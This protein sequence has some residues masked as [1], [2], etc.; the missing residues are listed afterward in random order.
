[1]TT[2][3]GQISASDIN[4]ELSLTSSAQM[5][6][7]DAAVRTLAGIASGAISYNSLRGKSA[8]T[9]T[10]PR[11]TK[12]ADGADLNPGGANPGAGQ[13]GTLRGTTIWPSAGGSWLGA[14]F[15]P[16][17][18]TVTIYFAAD[19]FFTAYVNGTQVLTGSDWSV[20]SSA[21]VNVTPGQENLIEVSP[22]NSGG[23]YGI[24]G[25]IEDSG[26]NVILTT[27][28]SLPWFSG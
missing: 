23:P 5:S 13:P 15:T 4:I 10:E 8:F 2:P 3:T 27:T 7:N 24:S 12:L 20:Y 9:R 28:T 14:Y 22:G 18:S 17:T 19:N 26:G 11:F 16:T 1:M 6:L 21:T 25:S